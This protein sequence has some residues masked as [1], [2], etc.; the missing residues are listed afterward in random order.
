[1]SVWI[2]PTNV[3]HKENVEYG[4]QE[5][6]PVPFPF[7]MCAENI[8]AASKLRVNQY[9]FISRFPTIR[10]GLKI[11]SAIKKISHFK[12]LLWIV[13]PQ[14]GL[15]KSLT[16]SFSKFTIGGINNIV[17]KVHMSHFLKRI[18]DSKYLTLLNCTKGA[19]TW[20]NFQL[21]ACQIPVILKW[22]RWNWMC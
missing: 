21:Q 14:N 20:S 2:F 6:F 16:R 9:I 5:P 1:M 17:F 3:S 4:P 18:I 22:M 8:S 19:R 7:W 15:N 13:Y 10:G 11:W 12:L